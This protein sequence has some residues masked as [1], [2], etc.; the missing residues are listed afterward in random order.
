MEVGEV[1]LEN[2]TRVEAWERITSGDVKMAIIPTGS[3][4]QHLTHLP[5]VHDIRSAVMIAEEA[6][7][8]VYPAAIVTV[9]LNAGI[10]EHHMEHRFGA[11][12]LKPGTFH[13]VVWDAVDSLVRHGI[14]NILILNGHG[15]NIAPMN[16]CINQFRRYFGKNIHFV[17]YWDFVPK[18]LADEVLETKAVPGHAQEFETS[19]ALHMF[20]DDVRRDAQA[21]SEDEGVRVSTAEKAVPLYDAIL[22]GLVDYVRRMIDG[23][24][25]AKLTGL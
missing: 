19:M 20:P 3:L 24:N 17:S 1:R 10:S 25:E 15:G 16:G 2:M 21:D 7:R 11:I 9:P 12:T 8:R 22:E 18:A 5:M 6:A 4:E 13:A 14:E 23:T